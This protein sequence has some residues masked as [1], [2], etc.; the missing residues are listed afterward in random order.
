MKDFPVLKL[1]NFLNKILKLYS[2]FIFDSFLVY[3]NNFVKIIKKKNFITWIFKKI[4]FLFFIHFKTCFAVTIPLN[5]WK[6][7]EI[8]QRRD[9]LQTLVQRLPKFMKL[10]K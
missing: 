4:L 3:Y 2:R 8:F 10:E 1:F 6:W 9:I 7:E 5:H